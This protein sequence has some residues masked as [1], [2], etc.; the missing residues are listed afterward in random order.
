VKAGLSCELHTAE[1]WPAVAAVASPVVSVAVTASF[2]CW[3]L[4]NLFL[5]AVRMGLSLMAAG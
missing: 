2:I 5:A 1:L 3:Q 4:S